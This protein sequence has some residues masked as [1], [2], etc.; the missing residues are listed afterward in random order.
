MMGVALEKLD[1]N[2]VK[3]ALMKDD[4]TCFTEVLFSLGS[5]D[6]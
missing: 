4:F 3:E 2:S 1:R 6:Q 5:A